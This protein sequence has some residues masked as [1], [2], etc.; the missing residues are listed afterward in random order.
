[1]AERAV[2]VE[3]STMVAPIVKVSI[4]TLSVDDVVNIHE[5]AGGGGV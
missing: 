5:R 3:L 4:G 1:M 2:R